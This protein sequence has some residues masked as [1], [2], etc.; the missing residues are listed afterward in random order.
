[1]L[2]YIVRHGETDLNIKGCVQGTVDEPLNE[3]GV[4]LTI[5]TGKGLAPVRFD[6]IISSPLGRAQKTAEIIMAYNDWPAPPMELDPRII[7]IDWGSWDALCCTAENNELPVPR[8]EYFRLYSDALHFEGAPDG[9]SVQ[10]VLKRTHDF[11]EDLIHREELHDKTVLISTHACASRAILNNVY[12]NKEDFWHG[13]VPY[14]CSVNIVEVVNGKS[15]LL[16]EDKIF[17]EKGDSDNPY[18]RILQNV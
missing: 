15:R 3:N 5:T 6:Y 11:Y 4:A 13:R 1:M 7:E 2:L 14:N 18:D 9:E 10:D 17:Y 12:N 16:E 8:E